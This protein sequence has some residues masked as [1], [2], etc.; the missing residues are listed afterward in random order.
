MKSY[1][2]GDHTVSCSVARLKSTLSMLLFK[3]E[4]NLVFHRAKRKNYHAF[5]TWIDSFR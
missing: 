4:L 5:Q 1:L 3:E 2:A